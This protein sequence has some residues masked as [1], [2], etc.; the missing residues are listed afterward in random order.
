MGQEKCRIGTCKIIQRSESAYENARIG[1][2]MADD[3]SEKREGRKER[4]NETMESVS[5]G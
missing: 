4:C 1:S 3:G 5:R 2:L